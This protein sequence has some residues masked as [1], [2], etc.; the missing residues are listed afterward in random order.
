MK[1]LKKSKCFSIVEVIVVCAVVA[2]L[3]S[4]IMSA[5]SS[6]RE[7]GRKT[8]CLNNLKQIQSIYEAYRKDHRKAPA[9]DLVNHDDF[10]FAEDYVS[11]SDLGT[12]ICPGDNS[13]QLVSIGLNGLDGHKSYS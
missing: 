13:N 11:E 4:L 2:I 9:G 12:F 3:A 6:V 8:T 1:T 5:S 10:S 7:A